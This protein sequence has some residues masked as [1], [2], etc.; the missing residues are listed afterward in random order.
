MEIV[1]S[2]II[3]FCAGGILVW[4]LKSRSSEAVI[5]EKLIAQIRLE[6][7]KKNIEEQKRLLDEAGKRLTDTFKALSSDVLR[8]N[9]S[10]FLELA[11]RTL[12]NLL[13]EAKGDLGKHKEAIEGVIKPIKESLSRY[14]T[15]INELE[16]A[17]ADAYGGLREQIEHLSKVSQQLQ[18]ETITLVTVLKTP[19]AR[20]GRWG[21]MTLRRLVELAG[22]SEYCD[23]EEQPSVD[24]DEGKMRPDL[25]VKLPGDRVVIVDAKTPL[26]AYVESI[27]L[28]DE[29]SKKDALRRHSSAV[30]NHMVSLCSKAYWNQFESTPDLVV[31]FLPGE[32]LF[33]AAVEQ[34]RSLIEDAIKARVMIATPTTLATLLMTVAYSW[35]QQK[36]AENAHN[37]AEAGKELFERLSKFSEHLNN[38]RNGLDKAAESYNAAIGAWEYRIVPGAKKLKELGCA[39]PEQELKDIDPL[40]KSLRELSNGAA[41]KTVTPENR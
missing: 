7:A 17:R 8:D 38:I 41:I 4:F 11:K 14:E 29:D 2:F 13:T 15:Q 24:T 31:M 40:E 32:S 23:F 27:E 34:D 22:M 5:K 25:I 6:E 36:V 37:I 35:R 3:G 26:S 30:R 12:D 1:F 18:R 16:K 19:Q 21:E 20:S 10:A 33:S 28:I 9:S 39:T